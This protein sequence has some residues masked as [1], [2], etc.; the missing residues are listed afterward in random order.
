MSGNRLKPPAGEYHDQ[1]LAVCKIPPVQQQYKDM[2]KPRLCLSVVVVCTVAVTAS[3][4]FADTLKSTNYQFEESALGGNSILDT[5]SPDYQASTSAG[6]LGIGNSASASFQINAGNTTTSDPAL[7]FAVNS[8]NVSFGDFSPSTTATATSSF[9]VL[10]YTSYG[11]VVQIF[12]NPPTNGA[13]VISGIASAAPS[14]T[15]VEQFGIN[16][17]ANTLPT[18]LGFNPD[19]GQFGTGSAAAGYNTSNSYQFNSGDTIATAPKSSGQTTYTISYIVNV[20][21]LTPG[22]NYTGGQTILC[23]GTY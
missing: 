7:A 19:H 3:A 10:D 13:H 16:L 2:V 21:S 9:Q 8:S 15:G 20:S 17:V 23:T 6:I 5:Q 12:G 14:Q 18:S 11:Y 4:A 22:G 1:V